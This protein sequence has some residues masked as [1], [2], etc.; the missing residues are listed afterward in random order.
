[1][2]NHKWKNEGNKYNKQD[3][4]LKCGLFRTWDCGNKRNYFRWKLVA[5]IWV[6]SSL[7]LRTTGRK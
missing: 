3:S 1:M 2:A 6:V 5:I 7:A 4:C